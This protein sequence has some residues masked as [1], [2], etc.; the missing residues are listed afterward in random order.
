MT[1]WHVDPSF[2]PLEDLRTAQ[3]EVAF[4]KT[5]LFQLQGNFHKLVQAHNAQASLVKQI[6]R[7]NTELLE[8]M[9]WVN[10]L[11]EKRL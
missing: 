8:Q 10:G 2:D 1:R 9:N 4:L 3:E 5:E 11:R 6:A 7:Q